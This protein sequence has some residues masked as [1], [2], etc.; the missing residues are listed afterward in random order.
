MIRR[1][2]RE[3]ANELMFVDALT[4][5][6]PYSKVLTEFDDEWEEDNID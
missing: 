5:N 3:E 6:E 2:L 1:K 4:D